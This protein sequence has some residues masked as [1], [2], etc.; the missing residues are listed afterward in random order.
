[1]EL[2]LLAVG[3]PVAGR[4]ASGREHDCASFSSSTAV[5]ASGFECDAAKAAGHGAKQHVQP[6]LQEQQ[7]TVQSGMSAHAENG[8]LA[9]LHYEDQTW[10]VQHTLKV[11]GLHVRSQ[12]F[13][14]I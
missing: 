2:P 3:Q 1:M 6:Q 5:M 10:P 12:D 11:D 4:P 14:D 8:W 7:T 13:Q 9:Q